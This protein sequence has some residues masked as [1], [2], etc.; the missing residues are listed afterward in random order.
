MGGLMSIYGVV[1]YNQIFSKAACLSSA[2]T[3]FQGQLL[4]DIQNTSLNSDMRVYLS[5][6]EQEGRWQSEEQ[7]DNFDTTL[8]RC[9]R[10]IEAVM[11][12]KNVT[13]MLTMQKDGRHCE[14]DW[15][16]QV[17]QF[18]DFLWRS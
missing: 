12:D 6:G 2:V 3:P 9:N 18:M 16:K 4:G 13:T 7:R 17:P 14:A 1:R 10:A 5:W 11:Q 15:A 8:A